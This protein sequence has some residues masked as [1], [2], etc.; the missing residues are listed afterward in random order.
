MAEEAQRTSEERL[1]LA[2]EGSRAWAWDFDVRTERFQY[3]DHWRS[4]LGYSDH[5]IARDSS[6]LERFVHPDDQAMVAR[7][8]LDHFQER[9]SEINVEYRV[10]SRDGRWLWVHDRGRVVERDANGGALRAVGIRTD[11]SERKAIDERFELAQDVGRVGT[12]ELD[13][14]SGTARCSPT[15]FEIYGLPR[16]Q[17]VM[18]REQWLAHLHA[19]DLPRFTGDLVAVRLNLE[20][21]ESE[22]RIVRADGQVRWIASRTH[23]IRG[24]SGEPAYARGIQQDVTDRK[25]AD[26]AVRESERRLRAVL[27]ATPE[28]VKIVSGDGRLLDMNRAGLAMIGAGSL[29][30]VSGANTTD[31]VAP[32]HRELWEANHKRVIGGVAVEWQFDIVGLHGTR[33]QIE[34]HAV[35][36]PLADGT[37][38]QLGITRDITERRRAEA[39]LEKLRAELSHVTRASAMSVLGAALAHEINQP[40]VA[41]ANYTSAVRHLVSRGGAAREAIVDAA[42][43]AVSEVLRAGDII[44]R[45]RLLVSK[46]EADVAPESLAEL[47]QDAERLMLP[48][49]R[50]AGIACRFDIEPELAVLADKVQVQQV[51]LNLV[52]NAA[53]AMEG[54]LA[55]A[56]VVSAHCDGPHAVISVEDTGHGLGNEIRE[57]LFE[58]FATTKIG[59]MGV[60]LSISRQIVE[61][62][63][64]RIWAEDAIGGGTR[65]C[66]TLPLVG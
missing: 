16:N 24:E 52:R 6:D 5:E 9:S 43:R 26:D 4:A 30:E 44:K 36:F 53:E 48:V 11:I 58:P 19:D 2:L 63:G 1:R 31:M 13:L 3:T 50:Q 20:W 8:M 65:F 32:E 46:G 54:S 66:F 42:E 62:H 37:V 27:E 22:Y 25:H 40:L 33:R 51:L 15:M 39:Q 38:G 21:M 7:A 57:R 28:C 41:A 14:R 64:G 60:G 23:V 12:F 56:L 34:C 45:L 29:S 10:R 59:G 47:L 17:Q 35:P 61:V 18:T 55:K 49:A